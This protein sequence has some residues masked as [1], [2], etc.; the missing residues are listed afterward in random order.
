MVRVIVNE[1]LLEGELIQNEYGGTFC[2]FKG[3][4]YAQPPVGDLRFKAPLPPKSWEGV[5][6]AKQFG[7]RSYQLD[8]FTNFGKGGSEDSLYLNVYTPDVKPDKPL[9]VMFWIHGGA[10]LCGTGEDELYGPEFL[11]RHGVV[12]VTINYRLEVLGFLCLDTEEIPGNAGL[13]DQVQ[14]LRWV[15]QNISNFGGDPNN[16][17]I[18]G[19]SAGG[20]SV[21]YHLISPMTKGLF[22]RAIPQSGTAFCPWAQ[23]YK[24]R[25]RALALAKQLGCYSEDDKELYEFFKSQPVESLVGISVPLLLS[26]KARNSADMYFSVVKEKQFGNNEI[27]FDGDFNSVHEDVEIM[28]GYTSEEGLVSLGPADQLKPNLELARDFPEFF[29]TKPLALLMPV[30]DQLEIGKKIRNYYFHN[31][32]DVSKDWEPLVN[33]LS[34]NMFVYGVARFAK[35]CA[36]NNKVYL[37]KF[38]C[39]TERNMISHVLGLASLIGS[40]PVTSHAD[41]IL[42]LFNAKLMP[43]KVDI[44]SDTFKLME[45]VM[46]LWTNFAKYG[47]P[48][49]DDSLGANW[50][51]FSSDNQDYL[52]IGNQFVAGKAP[53]AEELKFWEDIYE[54]Y[55][56]NAF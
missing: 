23:A 20:A 39:K 29:V 10:L 54:K 38:T 11:V 50:A 8:V 19:E 6:S 15:N 24:P 37:Y 14:A 27:F 35:V 32:I 30:S 2:S 5:R 18:F 21:S 9:P 33:F 40:K 36:K 26:E 52:E 55:G 16:I 3:I 31:K 53:D 1:G 17:T 51:P 7:P 49:P 42:Y 28:L 56:Q 22:K 13:K 12:V 47:N 34:A 43:A 4:P 48:T 44:N 25:D 41:D 45:K 46:T